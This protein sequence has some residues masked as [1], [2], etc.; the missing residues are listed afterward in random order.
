MGSGVSAVE[1]FW[2]KLLLMPVAGRI[3]NRNKRH[4]WLFPKIWPS[5]DKITFWPLGW[6]NSSKNTIFQNWLKTHP[7]VI[8]HESNV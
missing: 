7:K 6:E 5:S 8:T 3:R 2:F 1:W 4:F